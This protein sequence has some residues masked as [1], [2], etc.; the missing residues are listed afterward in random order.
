MLLITGIPVAMELQRSISSIDVATSEIIR[1][2][3]DRDVT[4]PADQDRHRFLLTSSRYTFLFPAFSRLNKD[5]CEYIFTAL[6]N[7]AL[8]N[9]LENNRSLNWCK[10]LPKF[11]PINTLGDGNCLMHAASLGMWGIHDRRLTLR[12]TVYQVLIEDQTGL[13]MLLAFSLWL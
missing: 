3:I 1:D 12:K 8:E 7:I 5:L 11:I 4:I 2:S 10:I 6:V 13:K 9:E